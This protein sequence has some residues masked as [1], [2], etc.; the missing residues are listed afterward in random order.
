MIRQGEG[1]MVEGERIEEGN[2]KDRERGKG[3][4]QTTEEEEEERNY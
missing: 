1:R 3:W 4:K 2:T